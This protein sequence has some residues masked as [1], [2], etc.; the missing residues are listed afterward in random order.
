VELPLEPGQPP[1]VIRRRVGTTFPVSP[2]VA[3]DKVCDCGNV[4][5]FVVFENAVSFAVGL[6]VIL[7]DLLTAL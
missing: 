2:K 5:V 7:S 3:K 6:F 1:P 4:S